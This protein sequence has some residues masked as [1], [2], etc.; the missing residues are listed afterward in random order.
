MQK[1]PHMGAHDSARAYAPAVR[2]VIVLAAL[3][4]LA[5]LAGYERAANR[6]APAATTSAVSD[7]ARD[8]L[9]PTC[10]TCHRSDL[11]TAKAGALAVFDL[12]KDAWWATI[13]DDQYDALLMRVRGT[14]GIADE[15]K[16]AVETFVA[17]I[18]PSS[19]PT[20]EP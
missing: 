8:A 1:M 5:S 16:A 4:I 7:H 14:S 17:S 3:G 20:P 6:P 2:P 10:G 13:K 11:P 15:D 12:T 18:R 9:V 19:R